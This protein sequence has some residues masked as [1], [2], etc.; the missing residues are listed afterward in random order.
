MFV[1]RVC[2]YTY[3]FQSE[4]MPGEQHCKSAVMQTL[5]TLEKACSSTHYQPTDNVQHVSPTSDLGIKNKKK[6]NHSL[7]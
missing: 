1:K 7:L 5:W 2:I 4:G 6:K 3:L